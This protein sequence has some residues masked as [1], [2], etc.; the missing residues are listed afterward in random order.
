M[1][2]S[3]A[4]MT[5]SYVMKKVNKSIGALVSEAKHN[6]TLGSE[7]E[8]VFQERINRV[9][10]F[11]VGLIVLTLS[12]PIMV[13]IGLMIRI[14]SPGPAIFRQTRMGKKGKSFTFYKFRTM[15][16]DA[17][18][19]F[20]ELYRYQYTPEEL[21]VLFFKV[22]NDPRLT[23]FGR[24][25]RKTTL[26]ELPNFINLLK[27]DM[28]LVGPRPDIAEML[29]YYQKWQEKKLEV[30]PGITGLAQ[31]NGRGLLSFEETLGTDVEYVKNKSFWLDLRIILKT[32]KVTVLRIGAF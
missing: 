14:D 23:R 12:F 10:S 15:F 32:I 1:L 26:D 13:M 19:R 25:L 8:T 3:G 7:G 29:P 6:V 24:R 28:N 21:N 4:L 31:V 27:G 18:E 11:I 22:P 30:K 20:P 2:L 16:V 5:A 9:L 17:K